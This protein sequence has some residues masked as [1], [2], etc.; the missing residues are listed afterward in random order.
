MIVQN[1]RYHTCSF[2]CSCTV[3]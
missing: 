2:I 1:Q 3:S